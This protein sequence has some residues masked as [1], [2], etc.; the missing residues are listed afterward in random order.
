MIGLDYAKRPKTQS[1][2][3]LLGLVGQ[4]QF[5]RVWCA[6]HRQ[7]GELVALKDLDKRR[8][9]TNLFLRELR[10]LSSLRHPNIVSFHTLEYTPTGRYLVLDYCESG[11]LRE[12]ME[13]GTPIS[14][15]Q[16]LKLVE[17]ILQGLAYAHERQV[18]HC[19]LKPE[20]ILLN[21]TKDGWVARIADFG[22]ARLSQE[23][24]Y[25]ITGLGA[26]GSPAY[27]APERFYGQSS[28]AADL[29]A[30]GVILYEL[31]L[32]DR[33]FSGMPEQ[34]MVAHLNQSVIVPEQAPFLLRSII[35]TAL[36]KLP[37]HRYQNANAMLEA[38]Q[39]AMQVVGITHRQAGMLAESKAPPPATPVVQHQESLPATVHLL[40]GTS[41]QLYQATTSH[42]LSQT[43]PPSDDSGW[44]LR[45]QWQIPL[46]SPVVE[47]IPRPQGCFLKL[48]PTGDRSQPFLYCLPPNAQA[49]PALQLPE[50]D[51][52]VLA[53]VW[54][55]FARLPLPTEKHA[56]TIAPGG[57][58]IA[59][60]QRLTVIWDLNKAQTNWHY[61]PAT[62]QVFQA[63][64]GQPLHAPV[65]C[66]LPDHLFA[67]DQR[68]GVA[69]F[70][71]SKIQTT[72][73][74]FFTRRGG[75]I[76][77]INLPIHL[78]RVV[79]H[80]AH[81]YQLLAIEPQE[82]AVGLCLNLKPLQIRRISLDFVPT[83]LESA[84]WGYMLA[85]PEGHMLL[86]DLQGRQ[87]G[88]FQLPLPPH[89]QVR[90]IS[91]LGTSSFMVSTSLGV[92]GQ[93]SLYDC[94]ELLQQANALG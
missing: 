24:G 65:S 48:Q 14:L 5:A 62:L 71:S 59:I 80:A 69:I 12:L 21:L 72:I 64:T 92:R 94:R 39:L 25:S 13:S 44:L 81:P 30:V 49:I 11:T 78:Q 54:Q 26:T 37:K 22:I 17:D 51:L 32:G 63:K 47:V 52:E 84:A 4:G 86:L 66:S 34:L 87:L 2:Y 93:L 18:I 57:E 10:L 36:Q 20:N 29:Y 43:I 67:L 9:P 3:R 31:L 90:A 61:R 8:F 68:Y 50:P 74:R 19:D 35:Q 83:Y 76:G 15:T 27:M 91:P 79:S 1:Q 46:P 6:V 38:L 88:Q 58:W 7:T 77:H 45:Q 82:P 73:L 42:L 70:S 56:L 33:P 60:A 53:N 85:N 28:P 23:S 16:R 40:K 75:F 89:Q 41:Q 55:A